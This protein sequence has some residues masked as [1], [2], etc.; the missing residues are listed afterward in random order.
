MQIV[1][2]RIT[3]PS[4]CTSDRIKLDGAF[5]PKGL[6]KITGGVDARKSTD[7]NSCPFG[8]KIV[9][10][11]S[12]GD[13]ETLVTTMGSSNAFPAKPNFI[14][15]VTRPLDGCGG[16]AGAAMNSG[17]D[18]QK[19]WVTSDG[20]PWW[21]KDEAY[22]EPSGDY[23]ANCF[24][25]V[26][27]PSSASAIQFSDQN[28]EFHSV[29]YLCQPNK[30]S[31]S[32][33]T[34]DKCEVDCWYDLGKVPMSAGATIKYTVQILM[35]PGS[36]DLHTMIQWNAS[37]LRYIS[38]GTATIANGG[39]FGGKVTVKATDSS[40]KVD[41]TTVTNAGSS[42][43]LIV[44]PDITFRQLS[45]ETDISTLTTSTMT[46]FTALSSEPCA[47]IEVTDNWNKLVDT[48]AD[49]GG[50]QG[51]KVEGED[52]IAIASNKSTELDLE[53]EVL[54]L[55]PDI[56]GSSSFN[57][58]RASLYLTQK[59]SLIEAGDLVNITVAIRHT[60]K[61]QVSAFD[62][63]ISFLLGEHLQVISTGPGI[64]A[65][66]GKTVVSVPFVL[67]DTPITLAVQARVRD[68]AQVGSLFKGRTQLDWNSYPKGPDVRAYNTTGKDALSL[69]MRRP[70]VHM[71]NTPKTGD[72]T[73][74]VLL[75]TPSC[76]KSV[77]DE[78]AECSQK[79][80]TSVTIGEQIAYSIIVPMVKG[81]TPGVQITLVL[82]TGQLATIESKT[83]TSAKVVN[84]GK[85][86][87]TP[88]APKVVN[89]TAK[90][91][92]G[93][94]TNAGVR[95]DAD[96]DFLAIEGT[97]R[98]QNNKEKSTDGASLTAST[99]FAFTVGDKVE[100]FFDSL[101]FAI[102][103]PVLE[104]SLKSTPS[105][106]TGLQAGDTID[107]VIDVAHT[108]A[109]NVAAQDVTITV[110][111]S[112]ALAVV[113]S[114]VVSSVDKTKVTAAA[115]QT[116]IV[117]VPI[118]GLDSD[119]KL[120]FT[121]KVTDAS[122]PGM[123]H[124]AKSNLTWY[125]QP[126]S[127]PQTR[128]YKEAAHSTSDATA[129]PTI[130]IALVGTLP[131]NTAQQFELVVGQEFEVALTVTLP[132]GSSP[133]N[134]SLL[135][136]KLV[137]PTDVNKDK[138][139]VPA[140]D[141][142]GAKSVKVS[143]A[144]AIYHGFDKPLQFNAP[145]GERVPLQLKVNL[146]L[147]I[148]EKASNIHGVVFPLSGRDNYG[149]G[150]V[151]T[152][153]INFVIVEP[154]IAVGKPA[155]V[156]TK[157]IESGDTA[158]FTV[159]L[160]ASIANCHTVV[161]SL[162]NKHLRVTK[163]IFD[164]AK[165]PTTPDLSGKKITLKQM[166]NG[167]K[168]TVTFTT[169]A[170]DTVT[171]AETLLVEFDV[172]W[173]SMP[174][175]ATVSKA[176]S[177]PRVKNTDYKINTPT[178]SMKVVSST[179]STTGVSMFRAPNEDVVVGES[180][181]CSITVDLIRGTQP[182]A[183][184][185]QLPQKNVLRPTHYTVDSVAAAVINATTKKTSTKAQGPT[186]AGKYTFDFGVVTSRYSASAKD[187]DNIVKITVVLL[188]TATAPT[189]GQTIPFS[190][191]VNYG[192]GDSPPFPLT[193]DLVEPMVNPSRFLFAPNKFV[194]SGDV[195]NYTFEV[196]NPQSVSHASA[197]Q[198]ILAPFMNANTLYIGSNANL[199]Y[200]I[201]TDG[202]TVTVPQI[203]LKEKFTMSHQFSIRDSIRTGDKFTTTIGGKWVAHNGS[204]AEKREYSNN[205][206]SV[207]VQV[208]RPQVKLALKTSSLRDKNSK[209][210]RDGDVAVGELVTMIATMTLIRGTSPIKMTLVL[211][212]GIS[213][214]SSTVLNVGST[215]LV[216]KAVTPT[217]KDT[218]NVLFD[219]GTVVN[220]FGKTYTPGPANE[221]QVQ[222]A[223]RIGDDD[224]NTL[225][226]QRPIIARVDFEKGTVEFN[227]K[228]RI[229]EPVL[230][231]Q[232]LTSDT[233][234]VQASEKITYTFKVGNL[235]TSNSHTSAFECDFS[236]WLN[237]DASFVSVNVTT[238]AGVT[239]YNN[240]KAIRI[241]EI[242]KG[243]SI[244]VMYVALVLDS[245]RTGTDFTT[246]I[247][248]AWLSQPRSLGSHR[249]YKGK[250]GSVK[251]D[252]LKPTLVFALQR[253]SLHTTLTDTA[254]NLERVAV[255]ETITIRAK[256]GFAKGSSPLV[257][258]FA[259]PSSKT[260]RFESA[261]VIPKHV[262]TNI[263][264]GTTT[265]AYKV[266]VANDINWSF[267]FGGTAINKHLKY[268]TCSNP[269]GGT[270]QNAFSCSDGSNAKC[271]ATEE[272]YAKG[273]WA[274]SPGACII[275][276]LTSMLTR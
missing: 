112:E 121:A 172:Q 218:Q 152:D 11:Q 194:Q 141:S 155:S 13:W 271:A 86:S 146:V 127:T 100:H 118:L 211:P 206:K 114:S 125:S 41:F 50:S 82:P 3:S 69:Q 56:E 161:V 137:A 128:E 192:T 205:F 67:H 138:I 241:P 210:I 217:G 140:G 240:G 46:A 88:S 193:F 151:A 126:K 231:L 64:S 91:N 148:P 39:Q 139:V 52:L 136:P 247:D 60:E 254:K 153:K 111:L 265:P 35:P 248:G 165:Y 262:S 251:I 33:H 156:G 174:A 98:V 244:T 189:D 261:R 203:H 54:K 255:G 76:S 78:S 166:D 57:N 99:D 37:H 239:T 115:K 169:T 19:S 45:S 53:K 229:A 30:A 24:L 143:D 1:G 268:C 242:V 9:A 10:P 4:S 134:V 55:H 80:A 145:S 87:F 222:F 12:K 173:K 135:L 178:S 94:L 142:S 238:Q 185:L 227:L 274:P 26:I 207:V 75:L 15:D 216:T 92:E 16:C 73:A 181:T 28:C 209:Y 171:A 204:P 65:S 20:Q 43:A 77:L 40:M 224:A 276:S 154:K 249:S 213:F 184:R 212:K 129:L 72:K 101:S 110:I 48:L 160:Q 236:G 198:M 106:K 223:V 117:V 196:E 29:D 17:T 2:C 215:A 270:A 85:T 175:T 250:F 84:T 182:L 179:L 116:L 275:R 25:N 256:V 228:L 190:S 6:A 107:Y 31:L 226:T 22:T 187:A 253:T 170:L 89:N 130:A 147:R 18:A 237:A 246:A 269:L 47:T 49:L 202:N 23:K 83:V 159:A 105:A 63:L 163:M 131:K 74:K 233:N 263:R 14:V 150:V 260:M 168:L 264:V 36:G 272:C 183:V 235:G 252:I 62:T 42:D 38:T 267:T 32:A 162:T 245:I 122:R 257:L 123:K 119:G 266:S 144:E 258:K 188:V 81:L 149:L 191:I 234:L 27:R 220:K 195:L 225:G 5:S 70:V 243:E 21:L 219:F 230:S 109:S 177:N 96:V 51:R 132:Y 133:N 71:Y 180:V 273:K 124:V 8:W 59:D 232:S 90:W 158:M 113:P 120:K 199:G 79:K 200:S 186:T 197:Y 95:E 44:V 93:S 102:V 61:S 103:E 68:T 259:L 108:G 58:S 157:T 66:E 164:K 167:E 34:D 7:L 97:L 208:V 176:Y 201:S 221:I 104:S 214:A